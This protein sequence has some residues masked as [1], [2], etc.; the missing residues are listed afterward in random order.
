MNEHH[1]VATIEIDIAGADCPWCLNDSLEALR[2]LDG[3]L[4]VRASAYG[5][6]IEVEHDGVAPDVVFDLLRATLHGIDPSYPETV[7]VDVD[8]TPAVHGCRHGA[9]RC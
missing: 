1:E 4:A 6:C 8:P 3:V 2:Q 9:P 5:H 7:M